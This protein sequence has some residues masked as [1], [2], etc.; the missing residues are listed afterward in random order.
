MMTITLVLTIMTMTGIGHDN[1]EETRDESSKNYSNPSVD[2]YDDAS[3]VGD[4]EDED[5]GVDDDYLC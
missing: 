3:G 4:D 2:E 1:D 5:T